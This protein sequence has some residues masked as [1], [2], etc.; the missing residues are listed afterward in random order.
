MT[1]QSVVVTL[2]CIAALGLFALVVARLW[3]WISGV[4]T[5]RVVMDHGGGWPVFGGYG[6]TRRKRWWRRKRR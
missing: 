4:T 2:A 3:R 1:L 6:H 5:H